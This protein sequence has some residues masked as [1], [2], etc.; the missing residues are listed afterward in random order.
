MAPNSSN[1]MDVQNMLV[2]VAMEEWLPLMPQSN[3]FHCHHKIH[4]SF[5]F[6]FPSEVK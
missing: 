1:T 6:L 4:V 5:C 3:F 2:E